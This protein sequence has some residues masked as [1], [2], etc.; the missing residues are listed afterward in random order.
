MLKKVGVNDVTEKEI[1]CTA[2]TLATYLKSI[3]F[4]DKCYVIGSQGIAKELEKAKIN[5]FGVGPNSNQV[6]DP[7]AFD[8]K[9]MQ[10]DP[11]VKCVAVGF[12]HYFNYP[13]LV[14]ATSYAHGNP[15][16]LFIATN[17]DAQLPAG[18]HS[19]ITI[20]GTGKFK[21]RFYSKIIK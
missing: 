10:L 18:P 7:G 13:K 9:T 2:W 12:D 11:E 1:V 20:P 16:C 4:T 17:D 6:P 21:I 14:E 5:F 15:N 19:K 3:N 8:Y